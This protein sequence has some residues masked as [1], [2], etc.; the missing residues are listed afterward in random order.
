MNAGGGAGPG[1]LT[2]RQTRRGGT[3]GLFYS[4][5]FCPYLQR[6]EHNPL[7]VNRHVASS[8]AGR[9]P[10]RSLA[11][12]LPNRR[13]IAKRSRD[14]TDR[15]GVPSSSRRPAKAIDAAQ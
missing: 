13:V 11:G 5:T 14:A 7:Q 1:V 10:V 15:A 3:V 4:D 9:S 2:D 6:M 12:S 8:I